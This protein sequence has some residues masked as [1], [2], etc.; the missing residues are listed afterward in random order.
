[1]DY[2]T[3]NDRQLVALARSGDQLAFRVIYEK[4][5]KPV[6]SR[7][8][9][10]FRW[11]ADVDDVVSESFQ[12]FFAKLDSY[13]PDRDILPWLSTIATRTALDRIEAE[14]REDSKKEGYKKTGPE[15]SPDGGE[16]L[17]EVNPEEEVISD[18]VHTRLMAFLD[19]LPP[20]YK[21]IMELYMIEELEYGE[22]ARRTGLE[23]NTVRTR[24]RRGKALLS[25]MMLRGEV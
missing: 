24:I 21:T 4:Y 9:G 6:R 19:E 12:K 15:A 3:M 23:L 8:R 25:E 2:S 14:R 16:G 10:F 11:Q 22:I 1:M 20:R 13:D 17:T 18:E 7:V 5:V